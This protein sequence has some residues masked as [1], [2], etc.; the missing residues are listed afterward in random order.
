M[1][2]V[3]NKTYGRTPD[4]P[5]GSRISMHIRMR[6]SVKKR[7]KILSEETG[8]TMIDILESAVAVQEDQQEFNIVS[9]VNNTAPKSRGLYL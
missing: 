9:R 7:L 4:D 3:T 8:R 6:P 5:D 1:S 2:K